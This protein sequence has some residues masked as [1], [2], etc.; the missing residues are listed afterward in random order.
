MFSTL[1][2]IIILFIKLNL[3]TKNILKFININNK[4]SNINFIIAL[5]N[6]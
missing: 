5:L 6:N 1:Y 4:T 3:M 2:S